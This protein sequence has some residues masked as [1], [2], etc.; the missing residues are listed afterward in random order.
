M[1]AEAGQSEQ[2]VPAPG[3]PRSGESTRD[4]SPRAQRRLSTLT[5]VPSSTGW[6]HVGWRRERRI[7]RHFLDLVVD[8]TSLLDHL[9]GR[10]VLGVPLWSVLSAPPHEDVASSIETL[11]GRATCHDDGAGAGRLRDLDALGTLLY[12]CAIDGDELCG[13]L[14]AR[15]SATA[16]TVTWSDVALRAPDWEAPGE[17]IEFTAVSPV[18]ED[19][20]FD[21]EALEAEL[22]TAVDRVQELPDDEASRRKRFSL[23]WTRGRTTGER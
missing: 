5:L 20:V 23:P 14:S 15:I 17:M 1:N 11:L 18:L 6:T 19:L 7:E 16:D 4:C 13:V 2:T 22:G 8:G 9:G 21:R 3:A 12:V 10:D